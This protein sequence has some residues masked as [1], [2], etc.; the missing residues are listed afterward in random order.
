MKT[1]DNGLN[2]PEQPTNPASADGTKRLLKSSRQ[3]SVSMNAT[4]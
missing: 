2:N 3:G 4:N 1:S